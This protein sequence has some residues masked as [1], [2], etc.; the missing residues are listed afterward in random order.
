MDK[1][2]S[3]RA[4]TLIEWLAVIAIIAILA[5]LLLPA[6]GKAKRT[7]QSIQC[8]SNLKQLQLDRADLAWVL[9]ALPDAGEP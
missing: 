1:S 5:A 3:S 9:G 8:A 7:A 2:V 6:L 4:L